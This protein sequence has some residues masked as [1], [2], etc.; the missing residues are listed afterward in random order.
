MPRDGAFRREGAP[1]ASPRAA[2]AQLT[3][4]RW[5]ISSHGLQAGSFRYRKHN[6]WLSAARF[7]T[8]P[9]RREPAAALRDRGGQIAIRRIFVDDDE[10]VFR[11]PALDEMKT[12]LVF[13]A[14]G[15]L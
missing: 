6:A 1:I 9:F 4:A 2:N 8:W 15:R 7:T 14:L 3:K 12:V 13:M 5:L 11:V 10:R